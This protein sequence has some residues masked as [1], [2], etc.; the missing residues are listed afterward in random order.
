MN[1]GKVIKNEIIN[2]EYK[3][4]SVITA[5]LAGIM[6]GSGKL[7]ENEYGLGLDFTVS[8]E[9]TA[10]Y[11]SNQLNDL[12]NYDLRDVAVSEDRLN[13]KDKFVLSLTGE[14]A[15][16]ILSELD[17]LKTVD[18]EIQVNYDFYSNKFEEENLFKSFMRGLFLTN[19][20]CTIPDREDSKTGYHLE[21]PFS[22]S[23]TAS[24][25][26]VKLEKYGITPRITRRKED[27]VLYIK[28]AEEIKD[29]LAFLSVPVAVV[30]LTEVMI[31][32]EFVNNVNRRKNCDLGNVN[33]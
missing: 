25:T 17:I 6:R 1:F 30:K 18:N 16:D 8:D 13:N 27:Y 2:K 23:I 33:R 31:E 28:S 19:G 21:I 20:V 15:V 14:R 5:F 11:V 24:L 26:A 7:F 29:F 10:I 32:K 22:H 4:K 3:D 9:R 12:F